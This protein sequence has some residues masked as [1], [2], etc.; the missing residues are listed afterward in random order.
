MDSNT[1]AAKAAPCKIL[2]RIS[3]NLTHAFVQ[4]KTRHSGRNGHQ[5]SVIIFRPARAAR[6]SAAA[7]AEPITL[8]DRLLRNAV[9]PFAL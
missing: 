7:N 5:C 6:K 4:L 8:G 3:A 2:L 1:A 9:L